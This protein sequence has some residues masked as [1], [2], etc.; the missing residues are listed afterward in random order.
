MLTITSTQ[1]KQQTHL[2]ERVKDEEILI[3]KREK[4][5]A[6]IVS[7]ERYNELVGENQKAKISK[8]LEALDLLGSYKLGGDSYPQ[9]KAESTDA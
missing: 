4:P 9:I 5:F 1:I 2:L 8:K 7:M 6:V 3:T